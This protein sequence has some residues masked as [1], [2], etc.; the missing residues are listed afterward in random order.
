MGTLSKISILRPVTTVMILLMVIMG[1][2][3]GYSGLS[4]ALMPTIDLPIALVSTTYIGAGPNEIES[5]ITE[6]IEEALASISN[7]DTITSMSSSNSSIVLVQFNDGTDIDMAAIDMREKIDLVKSSLPEAAN[8]PMVIKMD[9]NA[10]P[11]YV[12]VTSDNLD[13][14]QLNDLLEEN[15]VNSL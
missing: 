7:V 6:P 15:I 5:L 11:I 14:A 3:L 2:I 8:D 12:G 4:L 1:G 13:L 10:Q 9:M